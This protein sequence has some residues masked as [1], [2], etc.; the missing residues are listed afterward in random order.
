MSKAQALVL[1]EILNEASHD[2][3]LSANVEELVAEKLG[4]KYEE[5]NEIATALWRKLRGTK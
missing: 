3:D 4:M 5:V 2:P 1:K